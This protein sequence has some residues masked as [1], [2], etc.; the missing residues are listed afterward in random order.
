MM[1]L[2]FILFK[3]ETFLYTCQL[4]LGGEDYEENIY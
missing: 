3:L 2:I 1:F 4:F